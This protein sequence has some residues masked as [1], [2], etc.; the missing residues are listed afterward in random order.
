MRNTLS[1]TVRRLAT[2]IRRFKNDQA[3]ELPMDIGFSFS[4]WFFVA[5]VALTF[6]DAYVFGGKGIGTYLNVPA[7]MIANAR[8]L[9]NV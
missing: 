4:A 9:M 5:L 2:V 6:L 1:R 8:S 3:G 7:D